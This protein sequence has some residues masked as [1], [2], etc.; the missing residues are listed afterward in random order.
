MLYN[1]LM[2]TGVLA[3]SLMGVKDFPPG[4]KACISCMFG[5]G[6]GRD[7]GC[8]KFATGV[9]FSV[10]SEPSNFSKRSIS[11]TCAKL[12]FGITGGWGK[13]LFQMD[14]CFGSESGAA[15]VFGSRPQIWLNMLSDFESVVPSWLGSPGW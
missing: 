9:G 14:F 4:L 2:P 1:G 3:V 15:G 13:A 11:A 7:S 12:G 10:S 5:S 8:E 6:A